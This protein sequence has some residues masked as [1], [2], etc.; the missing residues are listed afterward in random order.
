MNRHLCTTVTY[1]TIVI[2]TRVVS[3]RWSKDASACDLRLFLTA[4]LINDLLRLRGLCKYLI[5]KLFADDWL[6]LPTTIFSALS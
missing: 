5:E 4:T 3:E 2:D 6:S 1:N